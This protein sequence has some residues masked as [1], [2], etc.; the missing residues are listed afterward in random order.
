MIVSNS[1]GLGAGL[2]LLRLRLLQCRDVGVLLLK[3]Q[4]WPTRKSNRRADYIISNPRIAEDSRD[5]SFP[6]CMG[7]IIFTAKLCL[8]Y[9][10][11]TTPT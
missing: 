10:T 2:K 5:E 8:Y 11:N 4:I 3:W 6:I 7:E 1:L 9:T